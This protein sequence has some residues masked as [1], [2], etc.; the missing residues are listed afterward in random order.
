MANNT[1][2][3]IDYTNRDYYALRA[4]LITRIQT[5]L[6]NNGKTWN[7]T[8]PGDFGV[9]MAEAFAYIGDITNYYIDRVAN[10]TLLATATQRQSILNIAASYGYIPSGYRQATVPVTF[11]NSSGSDF[12]IPAGTEFV[13]QI[14][15]I[16]AA[17]QTVVQ[18]PY[19]LQ[20]DITVPAVTT[21]P[22]GIKGYLV[23]GSNISYTYPS[24]GGNDI[25]GE[26]IGTSNGLTN[27]TMVLGSTQV[28]DGSV[29]IYV[30]NGDYFIPWTQVAHLSD[31]GPT[32]AVYTLTSDANNNI[33]I[34]FGDGATGAV[35]AYGSLIKAQYI[36]GGGLVGNLAANSYVFYVNNIP[37]SSILTKSSFSVITVTQQDQ[38]YGGED[39]ESNDSIRINAPAALT[40]LQRAVT[41]ADFKNLAITVSGVG[42]AAA[43]ASTPTSI[44]VY[45]GPV[46]TDVNSDYYPGMDSTNTTITS[47]WYSL[48]SSITSFFSNKLQIGT[49][50]TVLPP[51]YV[52]IHIDVQYTKNSTYTDAQIQSAIKYGIVYGLGYTSLNFDQVIYPEQIEAYLATIPGILS[53]KVIHLY[54]GSTVARNVLTP[55]NGEL[56]VFRDDMTT[57]YPNAGL[58]GLSTTAGTLSPTFTSGTFTYAVTT[59]SSTAT[60]TAT[61]PTDV[62]GTIT[63]NGVTT[64]SGVASASITIPTGMSTITVVVTSTDLTVS[65]T[66]TIRVTK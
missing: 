51:V 54:R 45:A 37:A 4:D 64:A 5:R 16:N 55:A 2:M 14:T 23:H 44:A 57:A 40:T 17:T 24:A 52:P 53:I 42:K 66:Y 29:A 36:V 10:E 22:S 27:Q 21:A 48:Q 65:N 13:T 15:T 12:V 25:A 26:L 8:D 59:S 61:L 62:T 60:V 20:Y 49:T 18:L 43:Y 50:V 28:A 11:K 30:Q 38:S 1:P 39:P 31:Y 3:S 33:Y 56:F 41:L 32:D 35:P 6:A 34:K 9:V 7:A 47:A 63:I 19:T 46:I 58:V